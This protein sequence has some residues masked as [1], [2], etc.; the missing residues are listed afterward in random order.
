MLLAGSF[1]SALRFRLSGVFEQFLRA[2]DQLI[3]QVGCLLGCKFGTAFGLGNVFRTWHRL[4]HQRAV[5]LERHVVRRCT[6]DTFVAS[7]DHQQMA[8]LH[9]CI[10][11]Y[12]LVSQLLLKILHQYVGF[13]CCDVASRMVLQ[14]VAFDTDDVASHSHLARLQ[15]NTDTGRNRS[16]SLARGGLWEVG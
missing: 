15:V 3:D 11:V 4:H 14:Q 13:G 6:I 1:P 7:L 12:P 16:A 5:G 8:V 10:E 2:H 9:T